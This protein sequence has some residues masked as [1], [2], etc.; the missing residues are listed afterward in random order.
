MTTRKRFYTWLISRTGL[1]ENSSKLIR[2]LKVFSISNFGKMHCKLKKL[3]I[4]I[5]IVFASCIPVS[6]VAQ[7]IFDKYN[8]D[9]G[10]SNN[11]CLSIVQDEDG[12]IWIGTTSGL[13]RFDGKDFVKY[14]STGPPNQLP[15]NTINKLVSLSQHRLA[16][17]TG[18]GLAILNTKTGVARQLIISAI[19]ELRVPV[20][21]IEDI[22]EDRK[23]NL[24]VST[25]G[26]VYVF[27]TALQL[28]FRHDVFTIKDI[29]KKRLSFGG[30]LH[31]LPDGRIF[32]TDAYHL[33]YLLNIEKSTLQSIN[34]VP[35]NEFNLFKP[36]NGNE[37]YVMG[38]NTLGQFF[39]I[40][41]NKPVD[42]LFI[43]DLP[44]QK[45]SSSAL[46][47][48]VQ[49]F[50]HWPSRIIPLNDT[51]LAITLNYQNGIYFLKFNS[52]NLQTAPLNRIL[53]GV[54]CRDVM[55]DKNNRIWAV[56]D[57]GIF[58]QSLTKAS[59]NNTFPPVY[60]KTFPPLDKDSY[61]ANKE[62][63]GIIHYQQKYFINQYLRGVL[64]YDDNLH[65]IRNISFNKAGKRNLPWNISLYKKD[66]LLIT[67]GYG[68]LLLNTI[69]CTIKKFWQ[70]GIPDVIDSNGI[71]CSF[72][73][74]HNQLWTGVGGG[75]GVFRMNILTHAWKF[76]SPKDEGAQFKLRYPVC[77]GEDRDGNVW[78]AGAEGI[79]RWNQG[80]QIFDTLIT[81]LPGIG[82]ITGNWSYFTIDKHNNIW[83]IE[84]GP[85]LVKY[86]LTKRQIT[87]FS[88]PAIPPLIPNFINGPW[89]NRLWIPTD[90][91]LLSFNLQTE[92]FALIKKS[93]GLYDSEVS[94]KLYFDTSTN[95]L[96]AGFDN[97]FSWFHPY[98]ILKERKPVQT[99]IID[100][101]KIGDSLSYAGDTVLSFSY[102]EN[103]FSVD[104]TGIN[105]D[106]GEN[107]TY[108]YRLFEN[109][110]GAFI[111]IGEQKTVTFA[112]L[113][114]GHYTF[115][116]KTIL[117]DGTESIA[118]TSIHINISFPYYES[119]WFYM[120]L[121]FLILSVFYVLY[122]YRINQLLKIQK[123]RNS[124]AGDLHDDIGSTLSSITI[125]STLAK[126]KSPDATAVLNTIGENAAAIQENMS[127][128]VWAVNPKNDRFENVLQR[129]NQFAAEILEAKNIEY[130][131]KCD[132]SLST[133]K[134]SMGQR[135]NLYLFFKEVINNVAKH[136][137]AKQVLVN[138]L[139]QNNQI[140]MTIKDN[141]LGFDSNESLNGNGMGTLKKRAAELEGLMNIVSAP[142]KGATIVLK[143]K[144]T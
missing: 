70:P 102:K 92:Q 22:I 5:I 61:D 6:T 128:I 91:G 114:P 7:V 23:N 58:K 129:M 95:R 1:W 144:I 132:E 31:L 115:Q 141:G 8:T 89:D 16:V 137:N 59:F 40:R 36:W 43:I 133:S 18:E 50:I 49:G 69:D 116:V 143:F 67:T 106:D 24:I 98:D 10:L 72:I 74:S 2:L 107:N 127:D 100:I 97:A 117:T 126:S 112:N 35:A 139:Q 26:G 118:P 34:D 15:S 39:F 122:R 66:T 104:F 27:N 77:I 73:D 108:A 29:G 134:L 11:N 103:S 123:M 75:N 30:Q 4:I 86:N 109:K 41:Y 105:Y 121:I 54:F 48:H 64:V 84:K 45:L 87:S 119:W 65:F 124:I 80:K 9:N 120:L 60:D 81:A 142:N 131:F 20:N 47:F 32:M 94:G 25:A 55:V 110:P 63:A 13:N 90:R 79:T 38:S 136:S 85:T 138:I 52:S 78:M 111:N 57:G 3:I 28:V 51:T 17:G 99:S 140:E 14:Y 93:D 33:M 71:A 68:A 113:K 82:N 125:M 76:F 53:P 135:K 101:K 37:S 83:L 130:S 21:W 62:I 19:E 96:F 88:F 42:S 44:H 46:P 56:G 12:F